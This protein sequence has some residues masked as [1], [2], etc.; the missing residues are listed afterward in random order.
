MSALYTNDPERQLEHDRVENEN[1]VPRN[2]TMDK[3]EVNT[4]YPINST[5]HWT[6]QQGTP[7]AP[8][9]RVPAFYKTIGNPGVLGLAVHAVTLMLLAT[10]FM[11]W[12]GVGSPQ[13]YIGNLYFTAGLYMF[14]TAQ[15]CLIKGE[16][17]SYCVFGV[18]SGFY[19][20]F[21]AILTPAFGVAST[22]VGEIGS[23]TGID[24]EYQSLG[25]FLFVWNGIFTIFFFISLKT[26]VALVVVLGGVSIGVFCLGG[27]YFAL[28][29][30]AAGHGGLGLARSCSK[31]G[32]A[33]L[34]ISAL[35]GFYLALSQLSASVE[36][37]FTLPAGD[38]GRVWAPKKK[39]S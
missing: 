34:F 32:G 16:T 17:L 7:A 26:N 39:R 38:L 3:Q 19:L 25:I 1:S 10:Q 37:P 6:N 12:R 35:S 21:G 36:M 28:A 2:R 27:M 15:W 8:V 22:Y 9:E 31:A 11:G 4:L 30:N 18:F 23:G 13:V 20:S 24:S 33:F 5:T 29:R 14:T